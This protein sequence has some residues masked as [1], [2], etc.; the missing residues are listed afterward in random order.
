MANGQGRAE[1][2]VCLPCAVG[3]V[4]VADLAEVFPSGLGRTEL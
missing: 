3:L 1:V 2:G 4:L